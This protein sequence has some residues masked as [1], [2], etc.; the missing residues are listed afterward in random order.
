MQQFFNEMY[1]YLP[2]TNTHFLEL[3]A[4]QNELPT[5]I[6]FIKL[7]NAEQG[8]KSFIQKHN[9]TY[10]CYFGIAARNNNKSGAKHCSY[11]P[12]IYIDI[13]CG[14]IGHKKASLL[15]TK[16]EALN[17]L[18]R[19]NL[20]PN[21]IVDSG[22]GLHVYWLF[23][24]PLE[25]TP[26]NIN[27]GESLMKKLSGILGGDSTHDVSRIFRIPDTLNHKQNPPVRCQILTENYS[28]R[29]TLSELEQMVANHPLGKIDH[30]KIK[31]EYKY[32][33][34]GN[35]EVEDRSAADQ[36]II[37]YL[38]GI[39]F[40]REDIYSIFT[41]YP[42]TGK[43]LERLEENKAGAN[44]YLEHSIDNAQKYMAENSNNC[45]TVSTVTE[46]D[47]NESTTVTNDSVYF[48]TTRGGGVGYSF[49]NYSCTPPRRENL[50]NFTIEFDDQ[51]KYKIDGQILSKFQGKVN[52]ADNTTISF[53]NFSADCLACPAEFKK[54]L[55]N[56][57]G[58]R[59]AFIGG[60]KHIIEAIKQ[61]NR[62]TK[63]IT[64]KEFGYND[65]RTE[66]VTADMIIDKDGIKQV[67]TPILYD[68][69]GNG[70]YLGFKTVE[71]I[72]LEPLCKYI[73]EELLTW[74][75]KKVILPVFAYTFLPLIYPFI[76]QVVKGKPYMMIKGTS[77][78]GKTML[79][80]LMQH[81][82]GTFKNLESWT[83]TTTAIHI[84]GTSY[85]D[86]ILAVDD[87]KSQNVN[88]Y[89]RNQLMILLQNYSDETARNRSTKTLVV[90]DPRIIKSYLL[91]SAEDL[92]ITECSTIA[93]CIVLNASKQERNVEKARELRQKQISFKAFTPHLIQFILSQ[94]NSLDYCDLFTKC[95]NAVEKIC[96]DN[97]L[98]GD[99]LPR[100]INNFAQLYLAWN[101]TY[102]FIKK[103]YRGE[104]LD[105]FNESFISVLEILIKDNFARIQDKKSELQLVET[106]W[107]MIEMQ[108]LSLLDVTRYK[109][110]GFSPD[111]VAGYYYL[112]AN[113]KP[114]VVIKLS[115]VYRLV[116]QYL[117]TFQEEIG[118][119]YESIKNKLI[120]DGK[121]SITP[122][123]VLSIGG[124][125]ER[126]VYWIGDIPWERFGIVIPVSAN[127]GTN[128]INLPLG[129]VK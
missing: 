58:A 3:R 95:H 14:N 63:V 48:Y 54:Y 35:V 110:G 22:N 7:F 52:L 80:E 12:A 108:K 127:G 2:E 66:Y 64:V 122:S 69:V 104:L 13:D 59:V 31:E 128:I 25:I 79:I 68:D 49:N 33:I 100:L 120:E 18:K 55:Y 126:G 43:Y 19:V 82:F 98:E 123:G 97:N 10:S 23:D 29:H 117:R 78:C 42:T 84:R 125:S 37:T 116:K 57:C 24:K 26:D 67:D 93:R 9:D 71:E 65:S 40:S 15:K 44:A 11:L 83:S 47:P 30:K 36:S 115:H 92:V 107:D 34:F 118:H 105:K 74:N 76:R 72:E 106:M 21:V 101:I 113:E 114:K 75:E 89:H 124:E 56:I 38:S 16:E 17:F 109:R 45:A 20:E 94:K 91:I 32:K 70:N 27:R 88:E 53:D 129:N 112:S 6:E 85:K 121:I 39:G 119:S 96:T 51:V 46:T 87:L 99:N 4:L 41:Y 86:A 90:R 73:V 60:D 81:F 102:S 103:H 62:H 28:T 77:G 61:H 111:Q 5:K 50:T 1:K 8:I